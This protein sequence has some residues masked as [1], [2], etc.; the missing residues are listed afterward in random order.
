MPPMKDLLKCRGGKGSAGNETDGRDW[1]TRRTSR[2]CL[3]EIE[4]L[5]SVSDRGAVASDAASFSVRRTPA[6]V[7]V[8]HLDFPP[9]DGCVPAAAIHFLVDRHCS[10]EPL[11]PYSGIEFDETMVS[12]WLFR[13]IDCGSA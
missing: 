5:A 3:A 11:L 12:R 6:K 1:A 13:L 4:C 2:R 9:R 10:S 7:A 8:R